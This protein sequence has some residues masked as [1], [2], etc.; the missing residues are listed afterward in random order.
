LGN[1]NF[2]GKVIMICGN[3]GN[4]QREFTVRLPCGIFIRTNKVELDLR[5]SDWF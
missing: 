2:G 1:L 4:D 3:Y 5:L